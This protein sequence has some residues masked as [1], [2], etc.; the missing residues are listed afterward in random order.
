MPLISSGIIESVIESWS[1]AGSWPRP[2]FFVAAQRGWPD[3]EAEEAQGERRCGPGRP[4]SAGQAQASAMGTAALLSQ[5]GRRRRRT[6]CAKIRALF[7]SLFGFLPDARRLPSSMIVPASSNVAQSASSR[8]WSILESPSSH[9][10]HQPPSN[11]TSISNH[12]PTCILT[13]P[14]PPNTPCSIQSASQSPKLSLNPTTSYD[15]TTSLQTHGTLL[16]ESGLFPRQLLQRQSCTGNADTIRMRCSQ[17]E[18]VRIFIPWKC[19]L[20]YSLHLHMVKIFLKKICLN[21]HSDIFEPEEVQFHPHTAHPF[22]CCF[23]LFFMS[24]SGTIMD[25]WTMPVSKPQPV[26]C[27]S[28]IHKKAVSSDHVFWIN[29]SVWAFGERWTFALTVWNFALCP[30]QSLEL[31]QS[32]C[33]VGLHG[34]EINDCHHP[35]STCH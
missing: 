12:P 33:C 25:V 22:C 26:C 7:L 20:I 3:A 16:W 5:P 23:L 24:W 34:P 13:Y 21:S 2:L 30:E 11:S 29:M 35:I 10:L 6:S 27:S 9:S 17:E 31:A 8:A 32:A 1:L 18:G 19:F 28:S 15:T 14:P 4:P